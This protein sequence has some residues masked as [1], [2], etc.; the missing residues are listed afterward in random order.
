MNW[1]FLSSKENIWPRSFDFINLCRWPVSEQ[2]QKLWPIPG[3]WHDDG[4]AG[5]QSLREDIGGASHRQRCGHLSWQ[6]VVK[7]SMKKLGVALALQLSTSP[8]IKRTYFSLN[9][10]TFFEVHGPYNPNSTKISGNDVKLKSYEAKTNSTKVAIFELTSLMLK[11]QF[12]S[13]RALLVL[14]AGDESPRC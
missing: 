5:F 4:G 14:Y 9:L 1:I 2:R 8:I 3:R 7:V 13:H 6:Q 11:V 10:S 12:N